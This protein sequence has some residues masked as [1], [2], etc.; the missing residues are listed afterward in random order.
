MGGERRGAPGLDESVETLPP[1]AHHVDLMRFVPRVAVSLGTTTFLLLAIACGT[2]GGTSDPSE[3]DAGGLCLEQ[4]CR[5]DDQCGG[6]SGGKT[7]CDVAGRVCVACGPAA[8]GRQCPAGQKCTNFGDCVPSALEC[9]VDPQGNPTVACATSADCGACDPKHRL[10][11]GATKRCVGCT[12]SDSTRCV[13]NEVCV[14]SRCA[15]RCPAT[16][17]TNTDCSQCGAPGFEAHAC[18]QGRC[19]QCGTGV[20]CP[21]GQNCSAKGT[22]EKPCGLPR[23]KLGSC[24]TDA[25]C[26]GCDGSATACHLPIGGGDGR[27]GLKAA[28]CDQL[29]PGLT[30]PDPW[31]KVTNLCSTDANCAGV[32]VDFNVGKVIRD[33]TGFQSVKD[34]VVPYGMHACASVQILP[35]RSCG[36]CAPCRKD[37]ECAP[38]DVDQVAAQAFGPLGAVATVLLMDQVFGASDHRVNMYCD[39]VVSDYG[40]CRPCPN[41][42]APC[43]VDAPTSGAACA[44]GPC[45]SGT[46]L[47]ATCSP[48]VADVCVTDPFCCDL[49]YGTWDQNCTDTARSVCGTTC[50]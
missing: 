22:C 26:A 33:V 8:G 17:A 9:P 46:P 50:P 42:F 37:S 28:G 47:A 36:V 6:C 19:T 15:A 30:L 25:D 48:C 45:V 7:V 10:C 21:A 20:P 24:L 12:P 2:S 11:D 44:H 16:C 1:E 40:Y 14:Q 49:E 27:C 39:Q 13:A 35:E 31:N 41:P 3:V 5:S 34:A 23:K 29:G 43:G 4:S 38:I 18:D 32:S